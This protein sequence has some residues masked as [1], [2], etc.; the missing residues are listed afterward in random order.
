MCEFACKLGSGSIDSQQNYRW[1]GSGFGGENLMEVE[2]ERHDD[3]SVLHC[4]VNDVDV[5]MLFVTNLESTH[6]VMAIM[7]E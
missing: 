6:S 4:E 3:S 5:F 7:S 1:A 2:V